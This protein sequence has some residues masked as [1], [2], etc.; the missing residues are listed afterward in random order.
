[1]GGFEQNSDVVKTFLL[2]NHSGYCLENRLKKDKGRNC[3]AT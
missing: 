2:K 1:M 3:K